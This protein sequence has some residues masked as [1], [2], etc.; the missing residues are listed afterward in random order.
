M[1]MEPLW[2]VRCS[3]LEPKYAMSLHTYN[4]VRDSLLN[5]KQIV[6]Y[7]FK[8]VIYD[9]LLGC[10]RWRNRVSESAAIVYLSN[11][12]CYLG[13]YEKK[14]LRQIRYII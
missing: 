13:P 5:N 9:L 8:R 14:S 4:F 3:H 10:Q 6:Q 12:S 11:A 7:Y 1:N 2:S